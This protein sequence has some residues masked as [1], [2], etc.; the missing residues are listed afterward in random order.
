MKV[1]HLAARWVLKTVDKTV[2]R[3]DQYLAHLLVVKTVLVKAEMSDLMLVAMMA[4][5][6]A[7]PMVWP[8]A[9]N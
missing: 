9:A 4:D 7:F 5:L 2:A 6:K 3:S 8:T 1:V